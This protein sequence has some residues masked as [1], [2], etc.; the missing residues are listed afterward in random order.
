MLEDLG[1]VEWTDIAYIWFFL[2]VPSF[3]NDIIQQFMKIFLPLPF[4]LRVFNWTSWWRSFPTITILSNLRK[5]LQYD[6]IPLEDRDQSFKFCDWLFSYYC[7][8]DM[9]CLCNTLTC[10][11]LFIFFYTTFC[12][13]VIF[14]CYAD[15]LLFLASSSLRCTSISFIGKVVFLTDTVSKLPLYLWLSF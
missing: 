8:V 5:K 10:C 6:S 14:N 9:S 15:G 13:M 1:H 2:F 3:N 11:I 7:R 4:S 12:I